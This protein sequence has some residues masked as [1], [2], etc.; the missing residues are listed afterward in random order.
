V[1]PAEVRALMRVY[2]GTSE[3]D[4]A[5]SDTALTTLA[6]NAVRA[7]LADYPEG[8]LVT[9]TTLRP[10][11]AD[12][13]YYGLGQQEPQ[14][15]DFFVVDEV[16]LNDST[17]AALREVPYPQ[18]NAWGAAGYSVLNFDALAAIV[19]TPATTAGAPLFLVYQPTIP[20]LV[21]GQP[22]AGVP[23]A[24]HD[25]VALDAARM[26]YAAGGEQR[27]P[28]TYELERQD[29]RAQLFAYLGRRSR[30]VSLRRST[31]A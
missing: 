4:P 3:D 10:S 18:R 31:D 21:E 2:L 25:V 22:I 5:F 30:D 12:P 6:Q 16:R 1:T 20:P 8:V 27:W 13:H 14:I 26:A 15:L 17:G 23:V 29:R 9:T 11:A 19:T 7:L 24:F 28:D